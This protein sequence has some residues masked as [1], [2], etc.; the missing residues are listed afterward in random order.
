M[1]HLQILSSKWHSH[2]TSVHRV[3]HIIESR[4]QD[5]PCRTYKVETEQN[6]WTIKIVKRGHL[7]FSIQKVVSAQAPKYGMH[8]SVIVIQHKLQQLKIYRVKVSLT[9]TFTCSF[10]RIFFPRMRKTDPSLS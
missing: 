9:S 2:Y 8:Q 10:S 6:F 3:T 7:P 1:L 4:L 5:N